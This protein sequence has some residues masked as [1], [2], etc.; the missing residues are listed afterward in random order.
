MTMK[1]LDL[2]TLVMLLCVASMTVFASCDNKGNKPD[3]PAQGGQTEQGGG[4][5][6]PADPYNGHAYV[7]L[8]L[9][10]KWATCNVGATKPEEYGNY[11][12]WGETTPKT[13]YS[14]STYKFMDS[15]INDWN[16][17][18]KYTIAD[19]QTDGV[20]YDSEGN[21]IGDNKTVLDKEDDAAA[22]NMGGDW[23][24]P[25]SSENTELRTECT[26]TWTDDYNGT[27]VAGSIVTSK[28]N[29]NHIF[30]PAAGYCSDSGLKDAGSCG[31]FWSSSFNENCTSFSAYCVRF[32][33]D[34]VNWSFG[35][36]CTGRPVRG[37]IE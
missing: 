37:V 19:G 23:R 30:L 12:A 5:E 28:T 14:W 7:D 22:V 13:T 29:G 31:Y 20:W 34:N 33:S 24:M 15:N 18:N 27:G 2:R 16:G 26:W 4:E 10:V 1:K 3:D 36:R 8:G 21:F 25:T 9:S 6:T 35:W 11:Y 32:S 17:V